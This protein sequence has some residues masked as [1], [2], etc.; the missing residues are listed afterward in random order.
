MLAHCKVLQMKETAMFLNYGNDLPMDLTKSNL[1][2]W[3]ITRLE[4]F[5]PETCTTCQEKYCTQF[6][7]K[8]ILECFICRQ[9]IHGACYR[10]KMSNHPKG[11]PKITGLHWLCGH[12]EPRAVAAEEP[13][14]QL[15]HT[16]HS[17]LSVY[18]SS[19]S[20]V[21]SVNST[22]AATAAIDTTET[23]VQE[24]QTAQTDT[25]PL[26]PTEKAP[27][28]PEPRPVCIH[29][30]RNRCRHGISGKGCNFR[31]PKICK[32][33]T[34]YGD[35]HKYGC[36]KGP[37]C[38]FL[39]PKMCRNSIN[40][41]E[42]LNKDCKFMHKKGTR[43]V[44]TKKDNTPVQPM[45]NLDIHNVREFPPLPQ[46]TTEQPAQPTD[47]YNGHNHFLGI[48][49]AMQQ[50]LKLMETTQQQQSQAL[51]KLM[52]PKQDQQQYIYQMPYQQMIPINTG[53]QQQTQSPR[54]Y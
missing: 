16:A 24:T 41:N 40:N 20:T 53:N 18:S 3:I 17:N 37:K 35:K 34:T 13:V 51:Q 27:Q 2:N 11:L 10:N 50:Q 48:L 22:T 28:G 8:P 21:E 5:L 47:Q 12:C 25:T 52:E 4:N 7:D 30:K 29:F 32:K 46:Q 49:Q 36:S 33:Y 39:H 43:R 19:T 14:K 6:G 9:G 15:P 38:E 42:C 1:A 23:I 45:S 31:H 44:E 54:S 26:A